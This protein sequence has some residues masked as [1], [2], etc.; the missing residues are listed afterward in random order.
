MKIAV[1]GTGALGSFY[2]AK[3][4]RAGQEV[5]F[6]LRSDY[7]AVCKNGVSIQ[8]VDGDFQVRP[9]CAQTPAQIGPCDFVLIGL[10]TTANSQFPVLIPPLLH[11]ET[12]II[13]LQNG[14]GNEAALA[15]LFPSHPIL[16]GLCFVCLTRLQPG[17]IRHVGHGTI[18]LGEYQ[19][20]IQ[21]RT[22][23]LG[24]LFQHS[25]I[26][27]Q[28]TDDL[29]RAHWEKLVWNIPFNGLGVA[30]AAGLQST[31]SGCLSPQPLGRCLATDELLAHPQ[32]SSLVRELM[33]EIIA[34]ARHLGFDIPFSFADTLIERTLNMGAYKAS[35][36]ID[37]ERRQALELESIFLLPLRAALA[38]GVPIPRLSAL[39]SL[40]QQIDPHPPTVSS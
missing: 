2:G 21:P 26:P 27:C 1:V 11:P 5:H 16:G 14:L 28:L 7:S 9:H 19:Q 30:S 39:C 37:F 15:R 12:T 24:E 17:L 6:L 13:T 8:S 3:L 38:A 33:L 22:R 40:L 35:T 32:W 10:K 4:A 34:A 20:P 29:E 31:L 23:Q 25:A 18:V 36:V